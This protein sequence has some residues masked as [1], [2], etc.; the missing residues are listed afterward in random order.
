MNVMRKKLLFFGGAILLVVSV[1]L[2]FSRPAYA[3]WAEG[4]G[5]Q[6]VEVEFKIDDEQGN[7]ITIECCRPQEHTMCDLS[8]QHSMCSFMP[9]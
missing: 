8:S 7:P 3:D 5:M 4:K 2:L 9:D 6:N 1:F